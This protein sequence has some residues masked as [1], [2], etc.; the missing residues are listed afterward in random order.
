MGERTTVALDRSYARCMDGTTLIDTTYDVRMDAGGKDPDSCS[1]TLRRYHQLLWSKPL[2]SGARFDLDARL[3][4]QSDLGE[5]WFGSDAITHTYSRWL[6][7]ARIVNVLQQIPPAE[8]EVFYDVGCTVGAYVVFPL[9]VHRDGKWRRSINQCRGTNGRVR[10]RFDLTLECIRRHYA[11]L[12]SPL[13]E[14]LA[15]HGP[16]FDLFGS[17]IGYVDHFLLNDWVAADYGSIEFLK[18]FDDFVG[19]PL[20]AGS[21]GE[22]HEYMRRSMTCVAR[23]NERIAD[24][25]RSLATP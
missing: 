15:W 10:D 8:V 5:F 4:H 17:F 13:S 14:P 16:F 20:P 22:Y 19:D 12:E 6:R 9:Q 24:Y 11:G 1:K 18:D 25:A 7:P 23:R 3:H 2:P 21:P